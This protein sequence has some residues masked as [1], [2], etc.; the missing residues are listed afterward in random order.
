[1]FGKA[2]WAWSASPDT[3]QQ[4]GAVRQRAVP[5][6]QAP[7]GKQGACNRPV[8][9]FPFMSAFFSP[10]RAAVPRRL[11]LSALALASAGTWA[12]T[13]AEPVVVTGSRVPTALQFIAADVV[14][15]DEDRIRA[16]TAD[17]VEDLL[18][19]EAGL[20]LSRNGGPGQNASLF[21]R[22]A[23]G[24]STVVLVNGVRIGSAT[25][26]LVELES[27]SLAQIERIEVLRG[28]GSSLYGA[29]AMGGVV[30]IFTRRGEGQPRVAAHVA[31]GGYGASEGSASVSGAQ[32]GLDYALSL[33]REANDGVSSVRP[34]D[35]FGNYNPDKD[36]YVRKG[37][38][39]DLG[40]E[41]AAGQRI[42]LSAGV[43]RLDSQFDS[44]DF[45]GGGRDS[46]QDFRNRLKGSDLAIHHSGRWDGGWTT[47]LQY[48]AND[49][50]LRS[51]G[52][53]TERFRTRRG[54]FT[55]QATWA[56]DADHS[57]TMAYEHLVEKA[58]SSS[59]GESQV[60]RDNDAMV[61]AY[62]GRFG[63]ARLQA[64]LRHDDSS[65]YGGTTTGRLGGSVEIAP[66][67]RVRALA[68]TTF[69]APS[70]NDLY[71]P[72]YG[73]DPGDGGI[74]PE[75][76][77]SVE[78]GLSWKGEEGDA[79][80]TVYRNKLRD[81]I[82]YESVAGNCPVP[83]EYPFG[84]A[85]NIGRARLQGATL[86]GGYRWG[87]LSLRGSVDLLDAIDEDTGAR[88]ARRAAHQETLSADYTLGDWRLG[89]AVLRVGQRPDAGAQLAGYT[90]LDL[91]ATWR[92]DTRWQLEA[93]LLNATDRD[94][95]PARDYQPL[96][97]Q[98]W[99]GLRYD[100]LGF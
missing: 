12:Q 35:L 27:L 87:D 66:G 5:A 73:V 99:I 26:G 45:S 90:T 89:A 30:Q 69:R 81:L 11:C 71:F 51:G 6:S 96:G 92:F 25:L 60:K 93:R 16:S 80:L 22:G 20:Q 50:D 43:R 100:G 10:R 64:D 95:Q 72:G 38:Q 58:E 40:Y 94:Y 68:G 53:T 48:A 23:G 82:G 46:G 83:E 21:I 52:T 91:K 1:M 56:A 76:G 15:I 2:A 85:A 75:R 77:R 84:C 57:L 14:L 36:G 7:A 29:D 74:A 9:L 37:A 44:T 17:S 34:G 49:D 41:V 70:F 4:E 13:A 59:Y 39:V 98:A 55:A 78:L 88:L 19:R 63:P 31:A 97:R 65:D 18:R 28:P 62:S 24:S 33:S 42:G 54:Q 47:Q 3:G 61:L 67:W 8:S 86:S 79:A 32:G